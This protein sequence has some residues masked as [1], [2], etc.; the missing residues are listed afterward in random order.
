[1]HT[2]TSLPHNLWSWNCRAFGYH[3]HVLLN[4]FLGHRARIFMI[5]P[6]IFLFCA[7]PQWP[8]FEKDLYRLQLKLLDESSRDRSNP[9]TCTFAVRHTNDD[10]CAIFMHTGTSLPHNLWSWNCLGTLDIATMFFSSPFLG[11]T[12]INKN[13]WLNKM[14]SQHIYVRANHFLFLHTLRSGLDL[15]R[16]C[17]SNFWIN[18]VETAAI[19]INIPLEWPNQ[20]D[21]SKEKVS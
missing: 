13:E 4:S 21:S 10:F 15:R 12:K 6:I 20:N 14:Q 18:Q 3:H 2:A 7:M 5:Q 19:H 9:Y 16:T 8:G 1:M 11:P 17:N